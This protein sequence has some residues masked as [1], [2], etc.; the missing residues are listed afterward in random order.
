MA[1]ARVLGARGLVAMA[2]ALA[3]V[4]LASVLE[5]SASQVGAA[6]RALATTFR[7]VVPLTA[8]ALSSLSTGLASLRD[9]AWPAGRFGHPRGSVGVGIVVAATLLTAA[10]SLASALV[11]LA[12]TRI[13]ANAGAGA[14][15]LARDLLTTS[16]IALLGGGAYGAWLGLGASFGAQGGGRL[17]VIGIDFVLGSLSATGAVLPRGLVRHLLGGDAPLDMPQAASSAILLAT[18]VICLALCFARS[19]D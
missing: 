14:L 7:F 12:L 1:F 19:R 5:R 4:V 13:G 15:P 17:G 2:V 6:D 16:W 8:L 3:A 9:A 18:T 11:A 10:F